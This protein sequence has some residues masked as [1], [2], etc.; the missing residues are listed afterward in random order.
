MPR[1]LA[2]VGPQGA[3]Q[4]ETSQMG[5][6]EESTVTWRRARGTAWHRGKTRERQSRAGTARNKGP[7]EPPSSRFCHGGSCALW[8][9]TLRQDRVTVS[10]C[11]AAAVAKNG[12]VEE[13]AR[14]TRAGKRGRQTRQA[15][16]EEF[17]NCAKIEIFHGS[18]DRCACL[19]R[20]S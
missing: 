13:T 4:T 6:R 5:R 15:S 16:R 14:G 12:H 3:G 8:G 9:V 18:V 11:A 19:Q 1:C 7:R 10:L 2:S 17:E 20:R